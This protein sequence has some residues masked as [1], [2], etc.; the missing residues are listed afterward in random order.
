MP[1]E[2]KLNLKWTKGMVDIRRAFVNNIERFEV[3]LHSIGED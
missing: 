1:W 3:Y 2:K